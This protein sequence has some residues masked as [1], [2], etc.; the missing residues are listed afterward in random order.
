MTDKYITSVQD[1]LAGFKCNTRK[2]GNPYDGE[3]LGALRYYRGVKSY[4]V[5]SHDGAEALML[6]VTDYHMIL[7]VAT[8][9]KL[10]EMCGACAAENAPYHYENRNGEIVFRCA[11][12]DKLIRRLQDIDWSYVEPEDESD[13]EADEAD[14]KDE[15]DG[16]A[17]QFNME[18]EVARQAALEQAQA[19]AEAK[20]VAKKKAKP[21][22][23]A[24]A[25]R[26]TDA[27]HS[28]ERMTARVA[29][30]KAASGDAPV[31]ATPKPGDVDWQ[32]DAGDL[33]DFE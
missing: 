28:A 18:E 17:E 13:D 21:D 15:T 19:D 1:I 27:E 7:I 5:V 29:V 12:N 26:K 23:I 31:K 32:I 9:S 10:T 14:F 24:A 25:R 11:S 33:S 16:S 30:K 20:R 22:A 4:D 3:R 2:D 8:A 6:Y